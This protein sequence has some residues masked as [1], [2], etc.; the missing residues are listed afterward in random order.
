MTVS[1]DTHPSAQRHRAAY[2]TYDDVI[3]L[4]ESIPAPTPGVATEP[5]S[6][7]RLMALAWPAA[8]TAMLAIY[9]AL[10]AALRAVGT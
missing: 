1:R 5:T 9:V 8:I 3:A 10:L 2:D 6:L 7:R 4:W